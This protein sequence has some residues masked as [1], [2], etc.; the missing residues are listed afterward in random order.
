MIGYKP[1]YKRLKITILYKLIDV[2]SAVK[3]TTLYLNL[4]NINH[5]NIDTKQIKINTIRFQKR[6][7]SEVDSIKY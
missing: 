3:R 6:Q 1:Y 2:S 5:M 4:F 7:T